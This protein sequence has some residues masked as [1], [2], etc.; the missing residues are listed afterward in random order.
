V[1]DGQR[2]VQETGLYLLHL[3]FASVC[4]GLGSAGWGSYLSSA[5]MKEA[6]GMMGNLRVT[7][8][9]LNEE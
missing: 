4:V 3:L 2:H 1:V 8:V 6:V 5:Q 9:R 7:R